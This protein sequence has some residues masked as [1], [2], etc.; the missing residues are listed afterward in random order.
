L[1]LSVSGFAGKGKSDPVKRVG[2]NRAH[3]LR[4]GNP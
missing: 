2:K 4:F 1:G 3:T